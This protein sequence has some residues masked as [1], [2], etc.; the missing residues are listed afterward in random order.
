MSANA[1][2]FGPGAGMIPHYGSRSSPTASAPGLPPNPHDVS[3]ASSQRPCL[4]HPQATLSCQWR[5]STTHKTHTDA[6]SEFSAIEHVCPVNF[7]PLRPVAT[8]A[9]RND[10]SA[11]FPIEFFAQP[12]HSPP[13][14]SSRSVKTAFAG[15]PNGD[16]LAPSRRKILPERSTSP[17]RPVL[18]R[19]RHFNDGQYTSLSEHILR[20]GPLRKRLALTVATSLESWHRR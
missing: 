17:W 8:W 11:S 2:C 1:S 20:R 13:P 14:I 9:H 6:H 3:P 10:R 5:R 4:N 12:L 18:R 7:L 19:S 15:D 16:V